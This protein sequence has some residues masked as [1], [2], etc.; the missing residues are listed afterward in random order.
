MTPDRARPGTMSSARLRLAL[1]YAGFLVV[2]GV[3]VLAG[4]YLVLRYVPDYPLTAANPSE[5]GG[6]VAS[7]GEILGTLVKM[8]GFI[9][10]FLAVAGMTGGWILAGWVLR[11]LRRI[12]EA[13]RIAAT[14]RLDHRVR[15]QGRHDEFRRLADAFD[16]MLD[17]LHDAFATQ[18]RFAANASHELRTPLAITA[19]MLDVARRDPPGQDYPVLLDRLQAVNA[20]AIGLTEAL[21][22]LADANAISAVSEPVDLAAVTRAAVAELSGEARHRDLVIEARLD[23]AVTMGDATLLG[24][25]AG[26]LVQNAVRHN[27]DAGAVWV[28]TERGGPAVTL[29]VE[30]TGVPYTAEAA[31]Q[32]TEPFLRGDGR[33]SRAGRERGYGLGLAL[34]ARIVAVHHGTLDIRPR[35]AGGLAVTVT[36]RAE[37][38]VQDSVA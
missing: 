16:A 5:T 29:R 22:R 26:N 19:T 9:L 33:V 20:R 37:A 34:V 7:R 1:S 12:D 13:A 3:A 23:P 21:L 2:A 31:A 6:A 24:R 36:L 18:E 27:H 28:T 4:V 17:R 35:A 11:P 14:G 15:L 10:A 30:N 25:L 38:G 32:L 8:S